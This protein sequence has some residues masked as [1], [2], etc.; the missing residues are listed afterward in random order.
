MQRK[1]DRQ[2]QEANLKPSVSRRVEFTS[3]KSCVKGEGGG[4]RKEAARRFEGPQ[5]RKERE[6]FSEAVEERKRLKEEELKNNP[7]TSDNPFAG[8]AGIR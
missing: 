7:K 3:E 4:D 6:I 5:G 1:L 2:K 8:T